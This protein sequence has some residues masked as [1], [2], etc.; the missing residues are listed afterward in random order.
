MIMNGSLIGRRE[1]LRLQLQTQRR[2]IAQQLSVA[3]AGA[4]NS[5]PRSM[6]MRF[7]SGQPALLTGQFASLLIIA[8]LIK[9]TISVMYPARI[10]IVPDRHDKGTGLSG[11]MN[12]DG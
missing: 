7:L 8:R 12:S 1:A 2:L 11:S 4:N 6:T 10:E 9:S 3:P 5:Y